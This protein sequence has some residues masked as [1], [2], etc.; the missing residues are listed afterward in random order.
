MRFTALISLSLVALAAAVPYGITSSAE[1]KSLL[2][3]LRVAASDSSK[4]YSLDQFGSVQLRTDTCNSEEIVLWRDASANAQVDNT[5]TLTTGTWTSG[6]DGAVWSYSQ[7]DKVVVERL[8]TLMNAWISGASAW[9]ADRRQLFLNDLE[10]PELWV[11][12][13]T[14]AAARGDKAPN[15]WKPPLAAA[16]CTYAISWVDV[17]GYWGLSVTAAEKST[18][19][20][21][22]NTC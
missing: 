3:Q 4:S 13:G 2:R 9:D 20:S 8:V 11:V 14:V 15:A 1:A 17:K 22:L 6:W 7:R 16:H 18:L 21:M 19:T 10:R 5:C 12:T